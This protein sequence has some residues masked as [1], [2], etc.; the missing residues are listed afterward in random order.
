MPD[1]PANRI[2][3]CRQ[4]QGGMR[5]TELAHHLGVGEFTIARWEK[6]HTGIPDEQKLAMADL[7]GVDPCWLMGWDHGNGNG[8]A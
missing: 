5:R 8:A 3:K 2:A 7:F 1:L 6:G 4:M